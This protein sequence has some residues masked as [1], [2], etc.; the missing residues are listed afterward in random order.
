MAGR[1]V[2]LGIK[3]ARIIDEY[4]RILC[5]NDLADNLLLRLDHISDRAFRRVLRKIRRRTTVDLANDAAFIE[6]DG[7]LKS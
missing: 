4:A 1:T 5:L 3:K 7:V 2:G 6:V